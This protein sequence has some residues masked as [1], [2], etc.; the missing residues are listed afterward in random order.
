MSRISLWDRGPQRGRNRAPKELWTPSAQR[1]PGA[2]NIRSVRCSLRRASPSVDSSSSRPTRPA[3][4]FQSVFLPFFQ[5]G[6]P[7]DAQD[8]GGLH[9]LSARLAEHFGDVVP[10]DIL[11]RRH[12]L[13]RWPRC[14]PRCRQRIRSN[15]DRKS[16]R[17]NS[18]HLVISYA[19][20]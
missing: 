6:L 20:F 5:E 3:A 16:T 12:L 10:F 15:V 14:V 19:V 9:F 8:L 2:G 7:A 1:F 11:E 4:S 18:S 13:A 17:L